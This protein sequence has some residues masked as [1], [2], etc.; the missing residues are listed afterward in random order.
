MHKK[1]LCQR[2]LSLVEKGVFMTRKEKWE[3][4]NP[5]LVDDYLLYCPYHDL[6]IR[7]NICHDDKVIS[8]E[9]CWNREYNESDI[10]K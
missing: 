7:K 6:N 4:L 1:A 5:D 2:L 3:E 8:C 10:K 9:E